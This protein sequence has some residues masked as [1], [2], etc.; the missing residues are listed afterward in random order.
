MAVRGHRGRKGGGWGPSRKGGVLVLGGVARRAVH[1]IDAGA[2]RRLGSRRRGWFGAGPAGAIGAVWVA[3]EDRCAAAVR[4]VLCRVGGGCGET[5]LLEP[6]DQAA[7][8]VG[9]AVL[10]RAGECGVDQGDAEQ[11]FEQD[12]EEEALLR[13]VLVLGAAF[14]HRRGPVAV[15]RV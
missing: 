15:E 14:R 12:E 9:D 7:D 6:L 8:E 13:A 3:G 1:L 11:R 4:A 10:G 2:V 5:L